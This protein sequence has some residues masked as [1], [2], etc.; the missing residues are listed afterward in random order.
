MSP[1][2][3]R[4]G[5]DLVEGTMTEQEQAERN[6]RVK[7][8]LA[9]QCDCPSAQNEAVSE[10][11]NSLSVSQKLRHRYINLTTRDGLDRADK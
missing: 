1:A 6:E 8:F 5:K 4:E 7:R 3:W 2:P 9:R 10:S 11:E